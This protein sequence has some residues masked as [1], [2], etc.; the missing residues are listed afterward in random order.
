MATIA[1][2]RPDV[3]VIG[4]VDTHKDIHVVAVIDEL[5]RFIA[6]ESFPI[7]AH[8]YRRL[9]G[10]LQSRGELVAVGVEGCGSWG[11]EL[12]R[13]LTARQVE[14]VEVNRSNCQNRRRRGKTDRVDAEAAARAG[15]GGEAAVVPKAGT[16]PVEA[17]RQ[18]RI[19][20]SG[21]IKARTPAANQIHSLCD[22]APDE[23]RAT[24]PPPARSHKLTN[25]PGIYS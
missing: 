25:A 10:W 8:G 5:G 24:R 13:H 17:L 14:V 20:R 3:R 23:I 11:K 2:R 22:T 7:T 4:G 19:A 16:G 1:Q 15:L 21:A 12:A 18:L 6:A 9:L